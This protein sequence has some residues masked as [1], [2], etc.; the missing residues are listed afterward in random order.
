M[1]I[2]SKVP[3][4]ILKEL[5]EELSALLMLTSIKLSNTAKLLK[6]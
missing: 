3:L 6:G 1:P 5:A 2:Y 4:R